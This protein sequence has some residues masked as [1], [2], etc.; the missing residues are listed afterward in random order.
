[1]VRYYHR[2][3]ALPEPRR[4]TNGYRDY[5]LDDVAQLVRIRALTE[6]GVPASRAGRTADP[7][8]D[9]AIL[10]RALQAVEEQIGQLE[11]RR[12]R[13]RSL[14]GGEGRIPTDISEQL[15]S[16][17]KRL[18]DY[19]VPRLSPLLDRDI[20]ALQL[21]VDTGMTTKGTWEVLRDA[22]ADEDSL[23][24]TISGYV[25]WQVLGTFSAD[26]PEAPA[27]VEKC[28]RGLVGGIFATLTDTLIPG[29][30]PLTTEDVTTD[31]AQHLALP[32]L[33]GEFQT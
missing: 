19:V 33:V 10:F 7:G 25:A 26:N 27:L 20:R 31:G 24:A 1:M 17:R 32:T 29:D 5:D 15:Q 3:G 13:L 12:V 28:R 9:A 18:D 23:L 8:D 16:F 14:L 21:M 2:T 4:S 30:L 22:L 11:M 6:A